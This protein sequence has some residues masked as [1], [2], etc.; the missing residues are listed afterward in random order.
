MQWLGDTVTNLWFESSVNM[1][2]RNGVTIA[3][4]D[5]LNAPFELANFQPD[6]KGNELTSYLLEKLTTIDTEQND[7]RLYKGYAGAEVYLLNEDYKRSNKQKIFNALGLEYDCCTDCLEDFPGRSHYSEQSFQEELIDNYRVFLPNNYRD[8]EGEKGVITD[9]YRIQNNLYIHTTGALWHLPQNIQERVTGD[10]VSFIG[11]GDF[12]SIPPRKIT[13]TDKE[14]AGTEHN[15]GRIKTAHGVLFPSATEGKVFL[16]D[17]NSLNPLSALGMDSWFKTNLPIQADIDYLNAVGVPYPQTNNP[18]S[19]YGTGFVSVYDTE[20]ERFILSKKDFSFDTRITTPGNISCVTGND[21][22]IFD[23]VQSI[24]DARVLN[25][26][27]YRGLEDCKLKFT[28]VE[29][30]Q[31]LQLRD[32][33]ATIPSNAHIHYFLDTS[34]SF[35]PTGQVAGDC[36]LSIRDAVQDWFQTLGVTGLQLFEHTDTSERWV[37]FA[38]D[39]VNSYPIGT[40]L[41]EIDIIMVSFCN[42]AAN[43]T[44]PALSYHGNLLT[45]TLSDPTTLYLDDYDKFTGSNINGNNPSGVAI[46]NTFKSFFG[47][48]YP[49]VFGAGS[50]DCAG[51]SRISGLNSSKEFLSHSIAALEGVSLTST[52]ASII[53]TPPNLGLT[54]AEQVTLLNALQSPNNYPTGLKEF[55][56][57]GQWDRYSLEQTQIITS[58]EFGEDMAELIANNVV[59]EQELVLVDVAVTVVEYEEGI[60]VA[61]PIDQDKSWTISYS[62]EDKRWVSWHSYLPNFYFYRLQEFYSWKDNNNKLW[63]HN[64][65]NLYQTF[66][67]TLYPHII[68]YVDNRNPKE[69]K[70]W[71]HLNLQTRAEEYSSQYNEYVDRDITFNKLIAY[72]S[73]QSTGLQEIIVKADEFNYLDNQVVNT[74]GSI[75]ADRNER[76]WTLNDLRDFVTRYDLP[77]FRKDLVSLAPEYYTDKVVNTDALSN[78]KPWY[79][80]Q[81]LRDKYLVVRLIFDNFDNIRLV[82]NFTEEIE[83]KSYR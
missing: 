77:L 8:I 71:E 9:V 69:T 41:A 79:E 31:E 1:A 46:Y 3:I 61:E 53:L 20:S 17:G 51:G 45:D 64:T 59:V 23:D 26:W 76:D 37:K 42:E 67:G 19:R 38:Q 18:S 28:K 33:I 52:E 25:N 80:L 14:S 62:L 16:F 75:L 58:R 82:T 57:V 48:H 73:K 83:N 56:W 32:V 36:L 49:T 35:G 30:T 13:D 7:G 81:S 39:I 43:T 63:K 22:I 70:L 12:F 47:V 66:Y 21:Y 60:V 27:V 74:V 2:L 44:Q 10:I 65:P 29:I 34:G 72:T 4:T 54:S 50:S 6:N 24:I 68:E 40:N 55:G 11:T 5:F 15:W 78:S